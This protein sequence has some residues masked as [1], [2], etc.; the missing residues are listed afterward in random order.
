M[1]LIPYLNADD[2]EERHRH[3][4]DRPINLHRALA[5]SPE[6]F[7]R[8]LEFAKWMRWDCQLD[9]RLRELL[10]LQVGYLTGDEYEWSHH[11]ILAQQFGVSETDIDA[12][13]DFCEGR[14]STLS[15]L[16]LLVITAAMELTERRYL[17]E[18]TSSALL[19]HF[20][21][22][23]VA[24]IV[25]IASFY[26]MVVRVLGGLQIDVE[27]DWA[28][29]LTRFPL[30]AAKARESPLEPQALPAQGTG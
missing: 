17:S 13:I 24:D 10:I 4:L 12:L 30:P 1:A 21:P 28:A 27:E 2:L 23:T 18:T 22:G 3:L 8:F 9:P 14:P 5:N 7:S 20:C 19:H 16:E 11:V 26:N 25:M 15:E 29:P 6:G